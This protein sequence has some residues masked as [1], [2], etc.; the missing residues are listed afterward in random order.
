MKE[1]SE[2]KKT[3]KEMVTRDLKRTELIELVQIIQEEILDLK[4]ADAEIVQTIKSLGKEL[5]SETKELDPEVEC[6]I[7]ES[8]TREQRIEFKC[9]DCRYQSNFKKE[10]KAHMKVHKRKGEK[11]GLNVTNEISAAKAWQ[12]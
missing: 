10:I 8:D 11:K 5:E 6:N 4:I 2:L 12:H 3:I 1:I 9:N 7:K